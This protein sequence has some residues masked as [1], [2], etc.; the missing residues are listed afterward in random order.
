MFAKADRRS[1]RFFGS[2][3]IWRK[4][5]PNGKRVGYRVILTALSN[6]RNW[7]AADLSFNSPSEA[8]VPFSLALQP[9]PEFPHRSVDIERTAGGLGP[10]EVHVPQRAA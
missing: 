1:E 5:V 7:P 8:S 2:G 3:E 4:L 9:L 6:L 10:I